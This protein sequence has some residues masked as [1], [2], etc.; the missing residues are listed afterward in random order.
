MAFDF[1]SMDVGAAV[2]N[3][4]GAFSSLTNL[5]IA[6]SYITGVALV[7]RGFAMYRAFGQHITMQSKGGEVAGPMV[8][9][10]VGAMLIYLPSTLGSS[11]IT[12]FGTET[13]DTSS[14][15]SY[16]P[17]EG[18]QNWENISEVL[19]SY[20]NLIG[21]I[22]FVRGWIILAKMGHPGAQPGSVAKGITHVV[23]GVLLINIV[24][25]V[26]ALKQLFGFA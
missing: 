11:M 12:I 23:G 8:F 4:T 2:N 18:G 10:V 6:I 15:L 1:S 5:V 9:I 21:M 16:S 25:T 3:L 14:L 26:N 7:F 17:N 19:R 22:A 13:A 20:M 24:A